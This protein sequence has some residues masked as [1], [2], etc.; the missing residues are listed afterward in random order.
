MLVSAAG[1]R[2]AVPATLM[3]VCLFAWA[4]SASAPPYHLRQPLT[5]LDAW[6]ILIRI[7]K[8]ATTTV[9]SGLI[10]AIAD[11]ITTG[12]VRAGNDCVGV[13][14]AGGEL[15]LNA[16]CDA[17]PLLQDTK[18]AAFN[19]SWRAAVVGRGCT[20]GLLVNPHLSYGA[21]QLFG[22]RGTRMRFLVLLREP[23]SR[24]VSEFRNLL[25]I[26]AGATPS[27]KGSWEYDEQRFSLPLTVETW[28]NCSAC[29][30]GWSNRQTR[31]LGLRLDDT[32]RQALLAPV[33]EGVLER[34]KLNVDSMAWVGI[35]ERFADS[36]TL[37]RWTLGHALSLRPEPPPTTNSAASDYARR[38]A[39]WK[40]TAEELHLVG[41]ANR[42]DTRLYSH[43]LLRFER[44]LAAL[45]RGSAAEQGEPGLADG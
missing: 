19:E 27:A 30:I 37:L 18:C 2:P 44:E 25:D 41:A 45:R 29:A 10:S 42:V 12:A 15:L 38:V 40:P 5:S 34:A 3:A 23:V 26:N 33:T 22:P 43:A 39:S 4:Y 9:R 32:R 16:Y 35:V 28:L 21:Y 31:M 24:A 6:L 17:C 1:V 7:P 36:W 13:N 20:A 14:G 8:T 11:G